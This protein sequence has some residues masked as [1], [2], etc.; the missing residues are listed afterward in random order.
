MFLLRRMAKPVRTSAAVKIP[1]NV[2]VF[3]RQKSVANFFQ[4]TR[5]RC[6]ALLILRYDGNAELQLI[7]FSFE[8]HFH[9]VQRLRIPP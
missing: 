8:V 9:A 1:G 2:F 5:Y 7:H 4:I 6:R 3:P